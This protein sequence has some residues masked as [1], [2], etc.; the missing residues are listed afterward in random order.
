MDIRQLQYFQTLCRRKNIS[1]AAEMHYISQQGLSS[2][3]KKLE[4]ELGLALFT[5]DS[6]GTC[7]NEYA[8]EI[9][10]YV[11]Q[12]LEKYDMVRDISARNKIRI[13]GAV[14]IAADIMLLDYLPQGTEAKQNQ[15]FPEL[16][17]HIYDA[18]DQSAME[19]IL[20]DKVEIAVVSGPV[21]QNVFRSAELFRFPYVAVVNQGNP[22][23]TRTCISLEDLAGADIVLPSQ[24][25]NMCVNF[26][27][28]CREADILFNT[29]YYASDSQH[30]VY[31][32]S[33][34]PVV[35]II[36]SFYCDFFLQKNFKIIPIGEEDLYW[37]IEIISSRKRQLTEAALHWQE[38]I[39]NTSQNMKTDAEKNK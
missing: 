26:K 18:S 9:L 31:L 2:S 23:Y 38:Y 22:L 5:R 17:Y 21:D 7:P 4:N 35:G 6:K 34:E 8:L 1:A 28:K 32:C 33:G 16:V 29:R 37:S 15:L 39:I 36:S 12:L 3:I 24:K 10:P 13:S 25:S 20:K 30:L 27:K 14:E 19:D 11:E